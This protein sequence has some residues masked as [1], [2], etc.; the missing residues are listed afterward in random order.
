MRRKPRRLERVAL[1]PI[2]NKS[3][4]HP[5]AQ[6][7][8]LVFKD[9]FDLMEA[10]GD[11][12]ALKTARMPAFNRAR[13]NALVSEMFY[14]WRDLGE[15]LKRKPRRGKIEDKLK[16]P[17]ATYSSLSHSLGAEERDR[18]LGVFQN[19]VTAIEVRNNIACSWYMG[20]EPDNVS[21]RKE[22]RSRDGKKLGG[23]LV[24]LIRRK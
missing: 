13:R 2:A 19:F 6:P 8:W 18:F 21:Y 22:R 3:D 23:R 5:D 1:C 20:G 12:V 9:E 15:T 4:R 16:A 10:A 14:R 24:K 17:M 11:N 7:E